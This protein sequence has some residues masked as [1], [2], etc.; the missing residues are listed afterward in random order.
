MGTVYDIQEYAKE[1][2]VF[3]RKE[4]ILR[5]AQKELPINNVVR[6]INKEAFGAWVSQ[7]KRI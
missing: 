2:I 7:N 4:D 6:G 3:I 5:L 1:N